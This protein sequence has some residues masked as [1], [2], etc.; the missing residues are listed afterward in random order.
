MFNKEK[1]QA[2]EARLQK[3]E[4]RTDD[5]EH[6]LG[7]RGW[8]TIPGD[9]V[10]NYFDGDSERPSIR[11]LVGRILLHLGLEWQHLPAAGRLVKKK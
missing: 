5:L 2:L 9:D 7:S 1:I 11:E 8:V 10:R 3:L 6:H 4:H